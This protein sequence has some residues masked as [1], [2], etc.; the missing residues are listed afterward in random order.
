MSFKSG[1]PLFS[2]ESTRS[3]VALTVL[4]NFTDLIAAGQDILRRISIPS[5]QRIQLASKL[6]GHTVP[7]SAEHCTIIVVVGQE[8]KRSSSANTESNAGVLPHPNIPLRATAPVVRV[9]ERGKKTSLRRLHHAD[10]GP[11]ERTG[12]VVC[13]SDATH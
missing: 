6:K 13:D 12:P 10:S 7:N 5:H 8:R 3:V 11:P 4:T 9:T 1:K 2:R